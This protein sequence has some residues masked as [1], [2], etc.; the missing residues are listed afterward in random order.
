LLLGVDRRAE[1][2]R[3]ADQEGAERVGMRKLSWGHEEIVAGM[4]WVTSLWR[5]KDLTQRAQRRRHRD[6]GEENE[7]INAETQRDPL[8]ARHRR[9]SEALEE[10]R[11][12]QFGLLISARLWR[13]G[14]AKAGAGPR[15]QGKPFSNGCV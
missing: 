6:H 9:G 3:P 15:T 12:G 7:E 13:Y 14:R 11:G 4:V 8:E 10:L 1:E 2:E 5:R